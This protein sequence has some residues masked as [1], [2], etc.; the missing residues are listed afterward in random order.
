MRGGVS[1]F[2]VVVTTTLI[3]LITASFLRLQVRDQQMAS[4]Q[5]LSQSSYDSAQ[6]GVEDAKRFMDRYYRDCSIANRDSANCKKISD[7]LSKSLDSCNALGGFVG[8]TSGETQIQSSSGG[9]SDLNQAYTCLKIKKNSPDFLGETSNDQA[10]TIPLR[11]VSPF[12]KVRISWHTKRNGSN[13][14]AITLDSTPSPR[15]KKVGDWGNRP[16]VIKAQFYG[17]RNGG[18]LDD[19]NTNFSDDGHGIDEQIYYPIGSSVSSFTRVKLPNNKRSGSNITNQVTPVVCNNNFNSVYACSLEVVIGSD[20]NSAKVESYLRLTPLYKQA[21][22]KIELMKDDKVIDFDGVQP[23]VDSTGRANDQ[24]R[25]VESRLEMAG[26]DLPL[27]DFAVQ[28][29]GNTP[30]CKNFYVT[31][32]KNNLGESGQCDAK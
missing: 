11:G 7:A 17:Y 21:E 18:S 9:G 31:H 10:R 23:I 5:D 12:N 29:E 32:L 22:F 1:M 20:I 3:A 30:L 28:Q 6:A 26:N 14:E 25:R 19:L 8:A 24:F 16:A 2:I 4:T 13:N 27:P 15:L